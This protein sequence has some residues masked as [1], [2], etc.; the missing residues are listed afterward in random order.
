MTDLAARVTIVLLLHNCER[1]VGRTL[2]RLV[3][4]ELPIIAVD[5]ASSDGT[6]DVVAGYP[7][8]SL[9][10]LRKNIG[11]AGRNAGAALARTPYVAFCDDDGYFERSGLE[12]A[13]NA[14]DAFPDIAVVNARIVVGPE[15]ALDPISAEM[16][17][18]PLQDTVPLPG[19][20]LL[21]FMAGAI[22]ARRDAYLAVGGYSPAFFMGGEEETLAVP[23]VRRGWQ[24]RYVPEVVVHHHPSL[25]NFSRLRHFGIRNTLW[26]AW[27]HRPWPSAARYTR[28]IVTSSPKNRDLLRGLWLTARGLASVLHERRPVG[29]VLDGQLRQLEERRFRPRAETSAVM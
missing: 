26:N 20:R 10:R 6:R 14:L 1:W 21:G 3:E 11:A 15:Q 24:L 2:D 27:L 5:N 29:D 8:V 23:L 4:L 28:F 12:Y 13:A 7:D 22:V 16:Q 17:A 18:S 9:L 19:K 25:A